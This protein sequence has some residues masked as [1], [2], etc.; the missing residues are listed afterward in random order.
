M[1]PKFIVSVL[2]VYVVNMLL[3]FLQHG[4]L[5]TPDY[6]AIPNVMRS[7]QDGTALMGFMLFGQFLISLSFVWIYQ[8]GQESKAWLGQGLRFG[9][10]AALI[11]TVPTHFIY[12]AVA[13]FPLDL[14]IK[15][16]LYDFPVMIAMGLTCAFINRQK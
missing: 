7:E 8:R 12:H 10:A 16:V 11:S 13:Q 2:A 9:I 15:Q 3:S 1:K 6:L 4:V 14:M 5:L